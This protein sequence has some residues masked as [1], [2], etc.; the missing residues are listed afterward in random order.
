VPV[1]TSAPTTP[2]SSLV[3]AASCLAESAVPGHQLLGGSEAG[4]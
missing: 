2:T 4:L 1:T 3:S